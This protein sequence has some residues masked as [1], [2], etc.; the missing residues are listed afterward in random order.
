M[1][2][3]TTAKI[4]EVSLNKAKTKILLAVTRTKE[5]ADRIDDEAETISKALQNVTEAYYERAIDAIADMAEGGMSGASSPMGGRSFETPE[6]RSVNVQFKNDSLS[7]SWLEEK[8]HR[9]SG[10]WKPRK[11]KD[12]HRSSRGRSYGPDHFW[13]DTR[14]LGNALG[15]YRGR[16]GVTV[17]PRIQRRRGGIFEITFRIA[18]KGLPSRYLDLAIRRSLIQGAGGPDR[19]SA[20]LELQASHAPQSNRPQ[21]VGRGYW[22]EFHRPTMRPIAQR[23]GRALKTQLKKIINRR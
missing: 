4:D 1:P 11:F 20:I 12:G 8:Q 18:L 23:L 6:G 21:G 19:A 5:Y 22:P 10:D 9:A 7:S 17:K 2:A 14:K 3:N 13:L 15:R 16:G